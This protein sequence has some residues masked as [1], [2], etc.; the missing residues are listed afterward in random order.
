MGLP[1]VQ[2]PRWRGD[3]WTRTDGALSAIVCHPPSALLTTPDAR[4]WGP[5]KPRSGPPL[6]LTRFVHELQLQARRVRLVGQQGQR[7]QRSFAHGVLLPPSYE[8]EPPAR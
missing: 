2:G 4:E 5:K 7:S 3:L 6:P 1:V 8:F